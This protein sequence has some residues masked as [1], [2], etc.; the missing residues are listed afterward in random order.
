MSS[1]IRQSDSEHQLP[2]PCFASGPFDVPA[3]PTLF[4]MIPSFLVGIWLLY[5][6]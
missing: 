6:G 4:L 5:V 3:L 1:L 2:T